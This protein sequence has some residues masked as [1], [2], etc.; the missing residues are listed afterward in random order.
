MPPGRDGI[1]TRAARRLLL[2][3]PALQALSIRAALPHE[4]RELEELQR[5]ASL[6]NPGDRDALLAHP[7]AISV[8][9]EHIEGGLV[10]VAEAGG[11]MVG[12]AGILHRSDGDAELDALFVE[13]ESWRL[14]IGR[15][16]VDR[17]ADVARSNGSAGLHV[18]GNPH[19][20]GFYRSCGFAVLGAQETRFGPGL[21][22]CKPL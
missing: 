19:A 1:R 15:R 3:T 11:V 9:P 17:C 8:P 7:D 5:R 2:S 22:M 12:F 16:L 20:E 18:V 21:L 6:A 10:F 14:G 4:R 13:P